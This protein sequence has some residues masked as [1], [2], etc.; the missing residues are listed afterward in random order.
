MPYFNINLYTF[1]LRQGRVPG[2]EIMKLLL[3]TN[4]GIKVDFLIFFFFSSRKIRKDF[5]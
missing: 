2:G 1:I 3:S 4:T 5:G